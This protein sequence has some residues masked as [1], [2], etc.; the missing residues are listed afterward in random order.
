MVASLPFRT[1]NLVPWALVAAGL[2]GAAAAAAL[3]LTARTAPRFVAPL[4]LLSS[5][6]G[7]GPGSVPD[8][9]PA[10]FVPIYRESAA[11]FGLNWLLLA[12]VHAEETGFST[13]PT[14]YHGLNSAGCCAGPF[15]FNVTNGPPSTWDGHKWAFRRGRRPG[16]R[17]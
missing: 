10:A 13:N 9:I 5:G 4:A 6:A 1:D 7:T 3:V 8:G 11:A 14:T 2:L 16:S 17:A 12:S 15:Q